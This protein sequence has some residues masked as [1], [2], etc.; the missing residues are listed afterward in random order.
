MSHSEA[1]ST[2]L[3]PVATVARLEPQLAALDADELHPG[4]FDVSSAANIALAQHAEIETH[5]AAIAAEFKRFNFDHIDKLP[6]Y[7]VAAKYLSTVEENASTTVPVDASQAYAKGLKAWDLFASQ[8]NHFIEFG[9]FDSADAAKVRSIQKNPRSYEGVGKA[10]IRYSELFTASAEKIAGKSLL[11]AEQISEAMALG[12]TLGKWD[13]ELEQP[14]KTSEMTDKRRRAVTLLTTAWR[15]IRLALEWVR[16][17]E[18]DAAKI[19]PGFSGAS[20]AS[21]GTEKADP[22]PS[23]D[24]RDEK[25]SAK[26][27]VTPAPAPVDPT[28]PLL[29]DA[30]FKR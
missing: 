18:K 24:K 20:A 10:L 19:V 2:T 13:A 27:G 15:D 5:R 29:P 25:D 17:E 23:E 21:R 1:Q 7:A 12:I 3:D 16:R 30:P 6:D 28:K 26:G 14:K 11:S 8:A 9:V 4:N 22:A